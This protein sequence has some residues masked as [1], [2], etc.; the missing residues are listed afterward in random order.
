M[1]YRVVPNPDMQTC[2]QKC[3][4]SRYHQKI[5]MYDEYCTQPLYKVSTTAV[6]LTLEKKS[7]LAT[8][9]NIHTQVLIRW[10]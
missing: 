1:P 5:Y 4:L 2:R 3:P 8:W 9:I 6:S 7:E 10:Y